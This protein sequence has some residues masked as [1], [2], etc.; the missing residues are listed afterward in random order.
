MWRGYG[1]FLEKK[2]IEKESISTPTIIEE[3]QRKEA[4]E[5]LHYKSGMSHTFGGN[6]RHM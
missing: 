6:L 5:H 2:M 1:R 3:K 4:L